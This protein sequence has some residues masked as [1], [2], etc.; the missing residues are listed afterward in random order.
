MPKLLYLFSDIA[1]LL[2]HNKKSFK[3]SVI[4]TLMRGRID[5]KIIVS[6]LRLILKPVVKYCLRNSLKI[7]D[8]TEVAKGLFIEFSSAE[9]EARGSKVTDSSLS[10]MTGL[11]RRD[12]TRLKIEGAEPDKANDVVTKVIGQ[13]QSDSRYCDKQ[14]KARVISYGTEA[15]EFNKLVCLVSN[16]ITSASVLTELERIGAVQKHADGLKLIEK[17]YSPGKSP[18]KGLRIL[19]DDCDDLVSA[20]EENLLHT[21]EIP[22]MHYRT[23][24]DRVDSS[25]IPKLKKWFLDQGNELHLRAREYISKFD[26]DI[27]P[28]KDSKEPGRRVVLS[29]FSFVSGEEKERTKS[30]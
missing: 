27:N 10:V 8:L 25:A 22:H 16:D 9:L 4:Y 17:T 5:P 18:I 20:V 12:V 26:L 6:G 3:I 24:Y 15:S 7:Q 28:S 13:W 14:G 23:V 29:S 11:H 21:P 2:H 30:K 1:N 19:S